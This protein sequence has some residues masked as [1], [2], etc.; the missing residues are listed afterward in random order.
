MDNIVYSSI[1]IGDMTKLTTIRNIIV[2]YQQ[3]YRSKCVFCKVGDIYIHLRLPLTLVYLSLIFD[4]LHHA[5]ATACQWMTP[6]A[7]SHGLPYPAALLHTSHT[8]QGVPFTYS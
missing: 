1:N 4:L 3:E 6:L 7:L 2:D 5:A 8:G